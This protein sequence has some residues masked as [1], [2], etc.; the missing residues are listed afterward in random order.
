[1]FK[2]ISNYYQLR[3]LHS[4]IMIRTILRKISQE[5]FLKGETTDAVKGNVVLQGNCCYI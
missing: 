2:N 3:V 5:Q 4:K 1:M